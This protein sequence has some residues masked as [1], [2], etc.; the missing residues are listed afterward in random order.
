MTLNTPVVDL[1]TN[2]HQAGHVAVYC[3]GRKALD[4]SGVPALIREHGRARGFERLRDIVL[5][6]PEM[7]ATIGKDNVPVGNYAAAL[8]LVIELDRHALFARASEAKV[9][10]KAGDAWSQFQEYLQADEVTEAAKPPKKARTKHGK[11]KPK[12]ERASI[13]ESEGVLGILRGTDP[14]GPGHSGSKGGDA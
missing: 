10:E 2:C 5:E 1:C 3:P 7:L 12:A 13:R 4:F 14:A 8:K 11:R 6:N 9:Q